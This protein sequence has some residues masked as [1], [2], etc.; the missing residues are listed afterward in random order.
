[1]DMGWQINDSGLKVRAMAGRRPSPGGQ[2]KAAIPT[3]NT[4][5]MTHCPH[6]TTV[7]LET[8]LNERRSAFRIARR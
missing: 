4:A 8:N 5:H 6:G 1:M 7:P 2:P 3:N